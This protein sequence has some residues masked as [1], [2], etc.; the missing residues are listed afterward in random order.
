MYM[1]NKKA[2]I[3]C[4]ARNINPTYHKVMS[5]VVKILLNNNIDIVY[6]GVK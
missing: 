5:Y 6:G 4:S 1:K 3:F 2:A